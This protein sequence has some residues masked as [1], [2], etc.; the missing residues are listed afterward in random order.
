MKA[1][2]VTGKRFGRL[3]AIEL[4]PNRS[5]TGA[6]L[7]RCRC[8]CGK[9]KIATTSALNSGFVQSCGCMKHDAGKKIRNL[10]TTHGD[11]KHGEWKRLYH[12]WTNMKQRCQNPQNKAFKDYGGRGIQICSEWNDYPKFKE[13]AVSSGYNPLCKSG[14]MT[15]DRIDND[16]M[17]C[18]ENCRWITRAE[19]NRNQR[20]SRKIVVNLDTGEKF[21]TATEAANAY[22]V[23]V[24]SL[25]KVCRGVQKRAAN[26]RWAY[27]E[28]EVTR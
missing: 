7:W 15:I 6:R 4:L 20:R 12:V 28:K 16:G 24:S 14:E 18:P 26:C 8:D 2:D 17:Y 10:K 1:I 22:G 23:D 13:W 11:A 3:T 5:N 19:Q 21:N 9:E 25:T 27:F